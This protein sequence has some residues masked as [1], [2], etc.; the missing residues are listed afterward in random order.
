MTR[1]L[2]HP[3][4]R[5]FR[6][7]VLAKKRHPLTDLL[8]TVAFLVCLY[9]ALR[10]FGLWMTYPRETFV[11]FVVVAF[12]IGPLTYALVRYAIAKWKR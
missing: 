10:L 12:L 8:K 7:D 3:E 1:T 5:L 6:L 9:G 2:V 4:A 11:C